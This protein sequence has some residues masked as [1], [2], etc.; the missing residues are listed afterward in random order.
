MEFHL[1]L[2]G[3]APLT[4]TVYA[5]VKA[6]ILEGRLRAGDA[7]PA[8]RELAARYRLSRNTVMRAY[9][10]LAMEGYLTGRVGAGTFVRDI[11]VQP[12]RA[13]GSAI[14]PA[15]FWRTFRRTAASPSAAEYD[16]RIGAPD[17]TLFPWAEWRSALARQFRGPKRFRADA[18]PE[19]DPAL[20]EAIARYVGLSRSVRAR[21][22][23]VLVCSGAQQ[24][25]DLVA[26]VLLSPG[27]VVAVEDP[28]YPRARQLFESM[29][30]RV[31]PVRVDE[32]GLV[33]DE[34]PSRARLIYVTPSHQFP[35]G[36]PMSLSRRLALLAWSRRAG[37]AILEDDYDT[38][39]RLDGRPLEPLHSLDRQGRVFYVGTFSKVLLPTLR[40]GFVVAPPPLARTLA[41][42]RVLADGQGTAPSQRALAELMD[43]GLFARHA[44]RL[45]RTYRDR[46]D[47]V[48]AALQHKLSGAV[49]AWPSAA[50]LHLS[51]ECV[52]PEIAVERWVQSARDMGVAVESLAPYSHQ[53]PRAGLV[54]GYGLISSARIEEGISRLARALAQAR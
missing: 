34:L 6:A 7:L 3:S 26:R 21:A 25:F 18:P 5:Q 37:A 53:Q 1:S 43:E 35:L 51:A 46:R 28:G 40:L 9:E 45:L 14:Q 8:S 36:V 11:P 44:R 27:D 33:V 52:D 2:H 23:E 16:F 29:G 10:R 4:A 13:T 38:E 49:R 31:V 12:R 20:R 30:T 50:G 48:V 15:S 24:A 22:E 54:I 42:A 47:R 41:L 17:A 19:G 32:D 39:F